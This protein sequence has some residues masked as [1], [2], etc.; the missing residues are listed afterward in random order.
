[1]Y[2]KQ[3]IVILGSGK[4][5]QVEHYFYE[6]F[7]TQ[8]SSYI[9]TVSK[10]VRN[11]FSPRRPDNLRASKRSFV[12]YVLS[13]I[14]TFGPPSI[15]TLTYAE[16]ET[17][18]RNGFHDLRNFILRMRKSGIYCTYIA[19][20][21]YQKS[22]RLHLHLL[23]WGLPPNVASRTDSTGQII[24]G[25]ERKNRRI[26]KIWGKGFVDIV[27]TDG[28][29]RLASY[30]AKYFT[31]AYNDPRFIGIRLFHRSRDIPKPF[32]YN[33]SCIDDLVDVPDPDKIKS[34]Y[35]YQNRFFGKIKKITYERNF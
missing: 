3:K 21:E 17:S 5:Q 19:V 11:P 15:C 1:M 6:K 25:T 32:I 16:H 27:Q 7:P 34:I 26:A 8:K 30:L 23:M 35:I 22:G 29:E 2:V 20:P 4:T 13:A 31:K 12:R 10:R 14:A 28:S 33:G 9:R 18:P 24:H